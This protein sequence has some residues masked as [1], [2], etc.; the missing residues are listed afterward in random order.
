[1]RSFDHDRHVAPGPLRLLVLSNL[2][3]PAVR[4]GYEVECHGVVEHLRRAHDVT[5][6]TSTEG[7]GDEPHVR[8]V[9][10]WSEDTRAGVLRAPLAS[11]LAT[12]VVARVLDDVRPELIW[13][14][15]GAGVPYVA[16]RDLHRSGIPV[17]YRVCEHWF[18][19]IYAEDLLLRFVLGDGAGHGAWAHVART[20]NRLPP[21]R[22]RADEPAAPTAISWNSRYLRDAVGV[23]P[24]LRAVYEE[25]VHPVTARADAMDGIPRLPADPPEVVFVGRLETQKGPAVAVRALAELRGRHGLDARLVVVGGGDETLVAATAGEVGVAAHVELTGP[26]RGAELHA[27]LS[28]AS[29]WVIPSVW[30]EPAG[31]VCVEAALARVP[32][33]AAP[34]GGIPEILHD[35]EHAL[36]FE[37][38][39]PHE[40]LHSVPFGRLGPP[41]GCTRGS[42]PRA[43]SVTPGQGTGARGAGARV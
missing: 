14:W 5:V 30:D 24:A 34:V 16:L 21:L 28:R 11:L 18:G 31:T 41:T 17:A 4:G 42:T 19:G 29:A 32:A 7:D 37:A 6:V 1:V 36:L 27:R 9:L 12:R 10:P 22:V 3:P 13:V 26:L 23:P 39:C 8:R 38:G 40:S 25:I 15:N 33:V 35:E 43:A 20:A 2:Y